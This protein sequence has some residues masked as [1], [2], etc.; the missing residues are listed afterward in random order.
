MV[1]CRPQFVLKDFKMAKRKLVKF[2]YKDADWAVIAKVPTD[3]TEE[4]LRQL[5]TALVEDDYDLGIDSAE[6]RGIVVEDFAGPSD[7]DV[8][9]VFAQPDEQSPHGW[10]FEYTDI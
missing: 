7:E 8:R 10:R 9:E 3:S 6:E 4:Q 2:T 1:F 5:G